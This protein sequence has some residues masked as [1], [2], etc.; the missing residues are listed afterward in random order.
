MQE[1]ELF[2]CLYKQKILNGSTKF[3]IDI[4][5]FV[6]IMFVSIMFIVCYKEIG[7]NAYEY[8]TIC[9]LC[10][11][12]ALFSN[13]AF[14]YASSNATLQLVNS[15]PISTYRMNA[16]YFFIDFI[17]IL[18]L[19][20]FSCLIPVSILGSSISLGKIIAFVLVILAQ[21]MLFL[22]ASQI[23]KFSV[24]MIKNKVFFKM[25]IKFFFVILSMLLML[26][27][28]FSEYWK[29]FLTEMLTGK[30][31]YVLGFVS[32]GALMISFCVSIFI[33]LDKQNYDSYI[34]VNYDKSQSLSQIVRG[35][36]RTMLFNDKT[37]RNFLMT[38]LQKGLMI[39]LMFIVLI[40][41]ITEFNVTIDVSFFSITVLLIFCS[42]MSIINIKYSKNPGAI[43]SL[44]NIPRY[45]GYEAKRQRARDV[46]IINVVISLVGSVLIFNK[47]SILCFL[48]FVEYS[49]TSILLFLIGLKGVV[50]FSSFSQDSKES[51]FQELMGVLS[52]LVV[53]CLVSLVVIFG[54]NLLFICIT[55]VVLAF[56][57]VML[58]FYYMFD[59]VPFIK[60][61]KQLYCFDCGLAALRSYMEFY[62]IEL[63]DAEYKDI[64]QNHKKQFS[65]YDMITIASTFNLKI[66]AFECREL[67]KHIDL[68]DGP[69][70]VHLK[71]WFGYHFVVLYEMNDSKVL[72]GDPSFNSAMYISKKKFNR[73][74]T[75]YLMKRE[76]NDYGQ[77]CH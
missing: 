16:I 61:Y 25:L 68:E 74:Y 55:I 43:T 31:N 34:S 8:L 49:L 64:I 22:L 41:N 47:L 56:P 72:V 60:N 14:D 70:I 58:V 44:K 3:I 52:I 24:G 50:P 23:V 65:F 29:C 20:F 9:F 53:T 4:N 40:T 71:K 27:F 39:T 17:Y 28:R 69:I 1:I 62:G 42:S 37:Q 11:I 15:L 2:K 6:Y 26:L 51:K 7:E 35:F 57:S 32:I 33:N 21:S 77:C 46:L 45:T 19:D 30:Y 66:K 10:V 73:Q 54:F 5:A 59:C 13:E 76:G 67:E 36:N 63:N 48:F 12:L 18:L 75:G 38:N